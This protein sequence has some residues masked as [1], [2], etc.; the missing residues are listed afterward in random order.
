MAQTTPGT[1][2]KRDFAIELEGFAPPFVTAKKLIPTRGQSCDTYPKRPE[3]VLAVSM[4]TDD[5]VTGLETESRQAG[6]DML[7]A[8]R[9]RP[10]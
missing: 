5:N 3:M 10:E 8:A 1:G 7:M 6:P 9:T 2:D 4:T